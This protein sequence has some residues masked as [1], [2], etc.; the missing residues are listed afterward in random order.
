MARGGVGWRLLNGVLP[1]VLR[2]DHL[3]MTP[4]IEARPHVA[5]WYAR[6]QALPAYEGGVSKWL[7]RP[8]VEMFRSNGEA[9]WPEVEPLT[10]RG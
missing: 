9:V 2:L 3:A 10:R 8:V 6:V 4:L 1:Y 7:S 5:D